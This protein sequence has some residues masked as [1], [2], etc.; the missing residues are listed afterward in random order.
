MDS[1]S[2]TTDARRPRVLVIAHRGASGEAPE[3]TIASFELALEQGADAIALDVHLSRDDQ[4][5]VIRDFTLER[6]TDGA[7]PVRDH[8]VRELKRL[9]VGGWRGQRFRGQRIQTLHEVLERFRDRTRVWIELRGGSDLY[10]GVEER[11]V[12][13]IEI[14]DMVHRVVIQSFDHTT[15]A[16]IRRL[17]PDVPLAVLVARPPIEPTLAAPGPVQAISLWLNLLS[18]DT[19][20]A[21]RRAG[22]E[23]Y[24][25]TANEPAQMH[26]LDRWGVTGVITDR[27]G[28]MRAGRDRLT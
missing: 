9:D 7:G 18:E 17:N 19:A 23:C 26:R 11:L 25:W 3:N 12:S 16:Q 21:I 24:A 20:A 13:A 28:P 1:L 6:T 22:L 5:V 15:L 14:Y 4:P 8:S 10:P 2:E 27:P